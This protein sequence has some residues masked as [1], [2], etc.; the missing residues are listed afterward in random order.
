[1][2]GKLKL[3]SGQSTQKVIVSENISSLIIRSHEKDIDKIYLEMKKN[4]E[5]EKT[6]CE[7][8][9]SNEIKDFD[10]SNL[11]MRKNIEVD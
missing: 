6:D 7:Q 1:M 3:T 2:D 10:K 5:V 8:H 11:E 9:S 4:I